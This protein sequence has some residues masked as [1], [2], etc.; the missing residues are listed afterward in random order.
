[1][2]N[3]A[4]IKYSLKSVNIGALWDSNLHNTDSVNTFFV[5]YSSVKLSYRIDSE[6]RANRKRPHS[7][8]QT[9]NFLSVNQFL[10]TFDSVL[11]WNISYFHIFL[12]LRS[13]FNYR[14]TE[15]K[16]LV[17]GKWMARDINN[18]AKICAF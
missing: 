7:V 15:K 16:K 1:M 4:T 18:T 3:L 6:S 8:D 14:F 12:Y 17:Y 10:S 9:V 5:S 2:S 13:D 11:T